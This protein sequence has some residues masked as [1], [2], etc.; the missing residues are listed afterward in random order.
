MTKS[1]Q[2]VRVSVSFS[3]KKFHL[4]RSKLH[5]IPESFKLEWIQQC[6]MGSHYLYEDVL[7]F[8]DYSLMPGL[9][10]LFR[11]FML[12]CEAHSSLVFPVSP[13][14]CQIVNFV[15]NRSDLTPLKKVLF[16]LT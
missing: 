15:C 14:Q 7:F 5:H 4:F 9:F 8:L 16:R 12:P 11:D 1:N 2:E 13:R 3:K 10:P 6:L